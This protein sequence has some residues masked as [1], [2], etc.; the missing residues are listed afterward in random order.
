MPILLSDGEV[1][2]VPTPKHV[3]T[4]AKE[5]KNISPFIPKNASY[6]LHGISNKIAYCKSSLT[7]NV[8]YLAKIVNEFVEG[9]IKVEKQKLKSNE[10]MLFIYRIQ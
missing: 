10:N 4:I 5:G 2:N 3:I 6:K 8:N 9:S 1:R 7:R